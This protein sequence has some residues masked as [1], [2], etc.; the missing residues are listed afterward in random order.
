MTEIKKIPLSRLF[1]IEVPN[2][3]KDIVES[4]AKHNPEALHLQD[5]YNLLKLQMDK[6]IVLTKSYGKHP[7]TEELTRLHKKRV[8]YAVLI[9][10]QL[11]SL[12]QM[13]CEKTKLWVKQAQLISKGRL[14]YLGQKRQV[15]VEFKITEFFSQLRHSF[16]T[17]CLKAFVGLGLQHFLDEME[18]ANLKHK[19]LSYERIRDIKDRPKTSDRVLE[20]ETERLMQLFFE[21]VNFYQ[22]IYKDIDYSPLIREINVELTRN[23]KLLKTRI[24]TNKRKAKK[25]ALAA[26]IAAEAK[27]AKQKIKP[28]TKAKA[29]PIAK[30]E[31]VAVIKQNAKP[32]KGNAAV[33]SA[34]SAEVV[35]IDEFNKVSKI[36]QRDGDEGKS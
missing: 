8:G 30:L 7:L 16:N 22:K 29:K 17:E 3:L 12:A 1:K 11:K 33:V 21:Q 19:E 15:D 2:L 34:S 14:T 13:D 5:L 24:A 9:N 10:M 27:E 31:E 23:S 28:E 35:V 32:S 6:A 18:N 20:R 4:V 25:K 26:K 36:S